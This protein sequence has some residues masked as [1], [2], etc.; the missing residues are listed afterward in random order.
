MTRASGVNNVSCLK[1]F[2]DRS[3]IVRVLYP[4]V[5]Q[6]TACQ[7]LDSTPEHALQFSRRSDSQQLVPSLIYDFETFS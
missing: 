6:A 3:L 5:L 7:R 2:G 4:E 1:W